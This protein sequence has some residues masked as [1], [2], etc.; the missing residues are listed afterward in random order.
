LSTLA[1]IVVDYSRR[2]RQL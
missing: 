1:T 2:I